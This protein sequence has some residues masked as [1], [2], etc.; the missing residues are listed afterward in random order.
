M[1]V[2]LAKTHVRALVDLAYR[3]TVDK[4]SLRQ[5]ALVLEGYKVRRVGLRCEL[6]ATQAEILMASA[7]AARRLPG[8]SESVA[9]LISHLA[10]A[11]VKRRGPK[12]PGREVK[13]GGGRR[14]LGCNKHR[15][16]SEFAGISSVRCISCRRKG[17]TAQ[18]IRVVRG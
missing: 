8:L 16:D 14:C 3:G 17:V 9:P 15:P 2:I 1:I 11:P 18:R 6:T 7:R 12:E 10:D 4:S 13:S 5:A